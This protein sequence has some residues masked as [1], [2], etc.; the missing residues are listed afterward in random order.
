MKERRR[1]KLS[2]L[3][4][5]IVSDFFS[6]ELALPSGTLLSISYIELNDSGTKANVFTSVYP[7][8]GRDG[9]A[10]L[11]KMSENKATHF[12]RTRLQSK[13]SPVIRFRVI[14]NGL[15]AKW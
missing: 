10:N 4:Q 9:I 15:V 6:S 5:E 13:Y 14:E 7:D 3:I 1:E 2:A 8:E 12:L 11:L